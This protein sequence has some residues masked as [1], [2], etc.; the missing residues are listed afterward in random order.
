MKK[1]LGMLLILCVG[2]AG[3]QETM[4]MQVDRLTE[5]EGSLHHKA[6]QLDKALVKLRADTGC[7]KA[8]EQGSPGSE[9]AWYQK[10]IDK[11]KNAIDPEKK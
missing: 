6:D 3:N 2:C 11:A 8:E 4:R 5:Q 9:D 1:V 10:Y 7:V